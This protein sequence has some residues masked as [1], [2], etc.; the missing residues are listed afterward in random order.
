[1]ST[2]QHPHTPINQQGKREYSF[3][4]LVFNNNIHYNSYAR[5][6]HIKYLKHGRGLSQEL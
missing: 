1:M 3:L 2:N 4:R 6:N 5:L